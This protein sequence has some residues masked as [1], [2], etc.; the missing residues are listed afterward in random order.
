MKKRRKE[1]ENLLLYAQ[2]TTCLLNYSKYK[3]YFFVL[4]TKKYGYFKKYH[5][6]IKI[7]I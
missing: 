2:I 1:K 4:Q 6:V 3:H 5:F 7:V